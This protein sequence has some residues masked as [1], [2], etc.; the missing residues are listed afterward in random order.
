MHAYKIDGLCIIL[1]EMYT[2]VT[3]N[4]DYDNWQF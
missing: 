1:H 4:L 3:L 2:S